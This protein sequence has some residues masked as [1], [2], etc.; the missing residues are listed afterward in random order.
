MLSPAGV[1]LQLFRARVSRVRD[2][3]HDVRELDL[4]LVSPRE[5]AFVAGQFISFEIRVPGALHPVTRPYSIASPPRQSRRVT[6]LFNRVP[7]GPG[8]GFLYGLSPGDEVRFTGVAGMFQLEN[9][10]GRDLLFVVTGTGIAPI[11]SMLLDLFDRGDGR[12]ATLFW[13]VRGERDLYYQDELEALVRARSSFA[14]EMTLSRPTG[15]WRGE[16]GRV[17]RLVQERVTTVRGLSAYVCG[18]ARMIGDVTAILKTKGLCPI[19][20]EKYYDDP[21][22]DADD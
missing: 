18:N 5:I 8:S 14:F 21:G 17:T 7:G 13:G 20:R 15:T 6:L 10:S 1:A 11:R 12:A 19:H 9:A 22:P 16:T 4:D 3:T 2:L